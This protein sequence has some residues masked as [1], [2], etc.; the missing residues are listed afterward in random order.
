MELK[1][2]GGWGHAAKLRAGGR[3]WLPERSRRVP[4]APRD[5]RTA[6]HPDAISTWLLFLRRAVLF[7]FLPVRET[8][9]QR[10]SFTGATGL[11]MD[12]PTAGVRVRESRYGSRCS[13]FSQTEHQQ[14]QRESHFTWHVPHSL[15]PAT[16]NPF[17]SLRTKQPQLGG[18]DPSSLLS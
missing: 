5:W 2:S 16:R 7:G 9:G 10:R 18:P 6:E 11:A 12:F 13:M 8:R 14:S 17:P 15:P 1:H 4:P 3:A